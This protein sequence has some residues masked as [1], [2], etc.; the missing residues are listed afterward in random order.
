M[1]FQAHVIRG[2]Q[3]GRRL[4]FPTINLGLPKDFSLAP[5]VYAVRVKIILDRP[6]P[7][8][9]PGLKGLLHFGPRE[10]FNEAQSSLEIH[11][12]EFNQ[13]LYNQKVEV[14]VLDKLRAIRKFNAEGELK[15]QIALDIV[16][17]QPIFKKFLT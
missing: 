7:A 15:R 17:A 16:A 5:G 12:L 6:K 3:R 1:R 10:T 14:M 13:D 9:G 4:G 2:K 8:K 11:L